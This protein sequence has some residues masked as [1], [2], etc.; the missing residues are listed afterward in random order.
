VDDGMI[1]RGTWLKSTNHEFSTIDESSDE[2][3]VVEFD[4][5]SDRDGREDSLKG[6]FD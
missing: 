3:S 2:R 5:G 1:Q 4:E 6:L